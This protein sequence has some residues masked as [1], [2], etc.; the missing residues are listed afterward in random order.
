MYCIKGDL[1]M[2]AV[3]NGRRMVSERNDWEAFSKA[4]EET[5]MVVVPVINKLVMYS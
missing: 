5:R 4:D 2:L 3:I 1:K